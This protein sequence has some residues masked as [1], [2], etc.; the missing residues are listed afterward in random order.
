MKEL[1]IKV[2]LQEMKVGEPLHFT[3]SKKG[4]YI[5]VDRI[6]QGMSVSWIIRY[7][8][9]QTRVNHI[10]E[11]VNMIAK[12]WNMYLEDVLDQQFAELENITDLGE[13]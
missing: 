13:Y 5:E 8:N 11:A 1:E 7:E 9:D 12:H 2:L 4:K 6:F 3:T 10:D